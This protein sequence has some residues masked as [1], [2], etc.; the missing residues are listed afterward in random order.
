MHSLLRH[1]ILVQRLTRQ[2]SF[3]L[4]DVVVLS[5]VFLAR[6]SVSHNVT[7]FANAGVDLSTCLEENVVAAIRQAKEIEAAN[8]CTDEIQAAQDPS[9]TV[10]VSLLTVN[11]TDFLGVAFPSS[12]AC[13][14]LCRMESKRLSKKEMST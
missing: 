7:C 10:D 4:H 12:P 14:L 9:C 5:F 2:L 8:V 6:Y 13:R 1:P 3:R 11:D